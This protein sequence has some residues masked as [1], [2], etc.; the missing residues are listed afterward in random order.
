MRRNAIRTS[1]LLVTILLLPVLVLV[2]QGTSSL[3]I[4]GQQG[5]ARVIQV[6]GKNYVEVEGL[7]RITGGSLRFA[8]NQIVRR[9]LLVAMPEITRQEY[10]RPIC[11]GHA[12]LFLRLSAIWPAGGCVLRPSIAGL[13]RIDFLDRAHHGVE[14]PPGG[15]GHH[16]ARR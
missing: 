16:P 11:T 8:R 15:R 6:Q 1:M 14:I 12:T 13:A 9:S 10:R 2:A 3:V 5:E 4:E 7:A